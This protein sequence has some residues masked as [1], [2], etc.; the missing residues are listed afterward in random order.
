MLGYGII[1]SNI[2][3]EFVVVLIVY[4]ELDEMS[5]SWTFFFMGGGGFIKV[6]ELCP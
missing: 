4:K 3:S 6:A 2:R 5:T 1:L